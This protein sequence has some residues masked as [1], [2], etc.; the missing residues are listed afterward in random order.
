MT[1]QQIRQLQELL[2]SSDALENSSELDATIL[3][4][5]KA[6]VR[7]ADTNRFSSLS[8]FGLIS[9][10]VFTAVAASLVLTVGVFIMM[11]QV[12]ITDKELKVVKDSPMPVELEFSPNK[13]TDKVDPARAL[14]RPRTVAQTPTSSMQAR[15]QILADMSLPD[16]RQVISTMEF[17]LD[18]DRALAQ[19]S[20]QLAMNDIRSM[21]GQGRL[22]NARQRYERLRESCE[23]CTLPNTLEA[24]VLNAEFTSDSS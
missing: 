17:S 10:S 16:V 12:I 9:P 8:I 4:A 23:V 13:V 19:Q 3:R 20:L 7:N 15:D 18:A 5:A 24:L 2:D 21:I 1:E 14:N 22:N 6:N 11:S